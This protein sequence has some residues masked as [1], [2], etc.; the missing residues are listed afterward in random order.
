[1]VVFVSGEY[2]IGTKNV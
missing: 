2:E 1:M